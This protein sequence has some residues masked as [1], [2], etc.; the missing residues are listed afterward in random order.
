[1]VISVRPTIRPSQFNVSYNPSWRN[2]KEAYD[3]SYESY[4]GD[5]FRV[6]LESHDRNPFNYFSNQMRLK[7]NFSPSVKT[8][9]SATFNLGSTTN[10]SIVYGVNTDS[11][12]GDYDNVN[13]NKGK[14]LAP[15]LD[16][17]L[18]H[19]FNDKNSLEAQVVGTLSSNSYNRDNLYEFADG[20][21]ENYLVD[22]D[23]HRRSL[24]SEVSY[25]HNFSDRDLSFRRFP[26]HSLP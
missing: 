3:N 7:Y 1:M 2:Y 6:D 15:S 9:F 23:A 11:F 16:L 25:I 22:V 10:K 18:R 17:F 26:K 12:L 20:G 14:D 19:D 13:K 21:K 8:L 5:D 4:I 24:I